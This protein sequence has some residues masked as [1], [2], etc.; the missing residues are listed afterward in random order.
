MKSLRLRFTSGHALW[1]AALAPLCLLLFYRTHYEWAGPTLVAVAALVATV[2]Y[3]GRRITGWIVAMFAW[4]FRHRRAPEPP[5]EPDVGATVEPG[6][7]VAVRWQGRDLVAIIELIP[8]PFTPTVIVDGK[9]QTDDVVDTRLLERLLSVHCPDLE[10]D[11][12]SAGHRVGKS[13]SPEVVSLYQQVIGDDPAPAFRRTWVMLR[14]DPQLARKSAQRRANG[15]T[16]LCRY[17]VASTTRIADQL[18]GNGVDAVCA[19][20]FDDFDHATEVSFVREKWSKIKG[21]DNFTTA[22][23]APGGPDVWWSV[24]ADHTI[25]RVRIGPGKPPRSTVLLTTATKPKRPRGFSRVSGGQRDALQG[26]T[27]VP[28]RHWQLPIGSAGVLVGE[29]SSQYRVYMPF[30][31]VDASLNLG[32]ARAFTQ[33]ALRS[34][35]AG[36]AVTL[37]PHF[38]EFATLIG[39]EIGPEAKVSW[40]NATTYLGRH[41]GVDPVIL[42]HNVISTPRHRQLP[43]RPVSPPEEAHYQSALPGRRDGS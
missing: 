34:A 12:V 35:A 22:Y 26:Q 20:S 29:T 41:P 3:R 28:G 42:R 5:S 2:T 6:D 16:G 38:Q 24:P 18:A 27:H 7:H 33:F 8:R 13:A 4:L 40:P 43:I 17:L 14:A 9:A 15:V 39:A 32:D 31:N 25:T 23:T 11:V 1:A 10:A 36:G 21:H 19:R 30:D 37:G